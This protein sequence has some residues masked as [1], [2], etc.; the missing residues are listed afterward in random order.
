MNGNT[1]NVGVD[2][3]CMLT[4]LTQETLL[5]NTEKR[6][7]ANIIYTFTGS[8]LVSVNPYQPLPIYKIEDVNRYIGQQ[9]GSNAPHLFAIAE[10]SYANLRSHNK[11]Q[12]ILISGESG[13]GKTEATKLIM[14]YLAA[15]TRKKETQQDSVELMILESSPILEA[16]GNA[17]TVRNN[18][19][20]RFGKFLEVCF[21]EN[22][23]IAGAKIVQ[24]LLEK[25]RLVYQA[26][27]E[28]NYHVFYALVYGASDEEKAKYQ[29]QPAEYY[30]YLNKSGC[31]HIN[32]V[33]EKEELARLK[34][35]FRYLG[36]DRGLQVKIFGILSAILLLGNVEFYDESHENN[37]EARV[38]NDSLLTIIA[39]L[40]ELDHDL[41]ANALVKRK[42]TI[43]GQD[44]LIPLKSAEAA[45][46]KDAMAK[47]L[48]GRL[49]TWLVNTINNKIR[50]KSTTDLKSIGILDIFGFEN[51][52]FNS[53]EQFCINYAN[54]KLQGHFNQHIF[55]IEQQE[56]DKEGINW[57]KIEFKDN[58]DVLDLIEK[59]PVGLLNLLDEECKFPR[60]SD[61]TFLQKIY[62]V[63]DKN[64]LFQK[65]RI[66]DSKQFGVSHYSG[67]VSYDVGGFLDKNRDNLQLLLLELCQSSKHQLLAQLFADEKEDSSGNVKTTTVGA[68]FKDQLT[69]LMKNLSLTMPHYVRCVKPNNDKVPEKFDSELVLS[70]LRYS[71]MLET[72]RIR[73]LGYPV[74]FS[75]KDFIW[76]F[77]CLAPKVP[78][79][80]QMET[81]R[82]IALHCEKNLECSDMF[83]IGKS[84]VFLRDFMY[85]KMESSRTASLSVM[86]TKCK[87]TWKM[88]KERKRYRALVNTATLIQT[89]TRRLSERKDY[90]QLVS[91]ATLVQSISR[92]LQHRKD[93]LITRNAAINIQ[94]LVHSN[95]TRENYS[96][97]QQ[98]A[99]TLQ[100]S[101]RKRLAQFCL[102]DL[103][104]RRD[105]KIRTPPPPSPAKSSSTS[106][107]STSSPSTVPLQFSPRNVSFRD[108]VL[109]PLNSHR[110]DSDEV[111]DRAGTPPPASPHARAERTP[112]ESARERRERRAERERDKE[113]EREEKKDR[114]RAERL[115]LTDRL[116][117]PA[118]LASIPLPP[119]KPDSPFTPFRSPSPPKPFSKVFSSSS[120]S[121]TLSPAPS[122][123]STSSRSTI[124][125]TPTPRKGPPNGP[126]PPPIFVYFPNLQP[127]QPLDVL[128]EKPKGNTSKEKGKETGK[129]KEKTKVSGKEKTEPKPTTVKISEIEPAKY[130]LS[131]YAAQ[132]Q[133]SVKGAV[134]TASTLLTYTNKASTQ[135]MHK[136]PYGPLFKTALKISNSV[137]C[138]MGDQSTQIPFS[139]LV[140]MIIGQGVDVPELRDE[141]Y[142]LIIKQLN[143]NINQA[144]IL[145]GWELMTFCTG[146]F[147]PTSAFLPYLAAYLMKSSGSKSSTRE[148]KFAMAS[149]RRLCKINAIGP[150]T[151]PPSVSEIEA[152]RV[153]RKIPVIIY[154][155]SGRAITMRVESTTTAAVMC[156]RM[157]KRLH[158]DI[159]AKWAFFETYNDL[160]RKLQPKEFLLDII[161][162]WEL[163]TQMMGGADGESC[164]FVFKRV[165]FSPVCDCPSRPDS[166]FIFNQSI[167]EVMSGHQP[168][169]EIEAVHLAA[170]SFEHDI[171]GGLPV[172]S[173]WAKAYIPE[174]LI[175]FRKPQEW[176]DVITVELEKVRANVD[177]RAGCTV[178][179]TQYMEF[180]CSLPMYGSSIFY[181]AIKNANH[182][183][184]PASFYVTVNASGIS[185]ISPDQVIITIPLSRVVSY[186]VE[187]AVLVLVTTKEPNPSKPNST[188]KKETFRLLTYQGVDIRAAIQTVV[189]SMK[190]IKKKKS[191]SKQVKAKKAGKATKA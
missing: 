40:L 94:G 157:C 42:M 166:R 9:L 112:P 49:F 7:K 4:N 86:A 10:D 132:L 92:S 99:L 76:R 107:S 26:P 6:F 172:P 35:A 137:M 171:R 57:A 63:H 173:D 15:M 129:G 30:Q 118:S 12:S 140:T 77:K 160:D 87:A 143:G 70:Q 164:K 23:Q 37:L 60:A 128:P 131:K 174:T 95:L 165:L 144:S 127:P 189:S 3:M 36:I 141:I 38:K 64:P 108:P 135:P 83:Q 185:F 125:A 11:D 109:S 177:K 84:K 68:Q 142:C 29:L 113:R 102:E 103:I 58:Q 20:S 156:K 119:R 79:E 161:Y 167:S 56:Y 69:T 151:R 21:D 182:D 105:K 188:P 159:T 136:I 1:N 168:V 175:P 78:S 17:K 133:S 50:A 138:Y 183:Y 117:L 149:H 19:S 126:I 111:G 170:L 41:L 124:F 134:T 32:G 71:G 158:L 25:S 100:T 55:S 93:F 104:N 106:T 153:H 33:N 155:P 88:H 72:I 179:E 115:A 62:T 65:S 5:D 89:F 97:L 148:R 67:L 91:A 22:G 51:F 186:E 150:R 44:L 61:A 98:S 96:K 85:M 176:L 130:P 152:V 13:S 16:F 34:T 146:C 59:R 48:Y 80:D 46:N 139:E 181:V 43:K 116:S 154:L 180:I 24:Y 178:L 191:V 53:F 187:G 120:V 45:E 47:G 121:N 163:Y 110:E 122:F 145:R 14:Q 162:K 73:K 54:E 28:R 147:A 2:D 27:D 31:T 82:G 74:R 81:A 90:A 184:L 123:S 52:P 8:I 169:T 39:S 101:I 66:G 190:P 18:N 114:E 75:F